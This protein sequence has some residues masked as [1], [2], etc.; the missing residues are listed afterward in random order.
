MV[1]V[2]DRER[3]Q[4]ERANGTDRTPVVF[5]H[6]LW[7]LASS[8]EPWRDLFEQQGYV[9]LAPG[10]P[11]EPE[12]VDEARAHPDLVAGS[13][14]GAVADHLADVVRALDRPPVLVGHSFGGLLVQK[15]AGLGLASATVA[16]SPAP[17]RGVL[18]L[19]ISALK[20]SFPVLRNPANRKRSV[21]LTPEQFRYA[22]TNALPEDEAA[23]VYD[24]FAVPAPG[25][26]LF[27]AATA[28][29]APRSEA[30]ADT[31]SAARGPMLLLG[32]EQDHTVPW[33]ITNASYKRQRKNAGFTD[34]T[35]IP[36]RGHSLVVDD[37]WPD[38]AAKALAFL[39]EHAPTSGALA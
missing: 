10:W 2:T 21:M 31:S 33:A 15:L 23:R 28:N 8:W 4:V 17:A 9:A 14:V 24:R 39:A 12:T 26:P 35:E 34:V 27:Q 20:A 22:F 37:G 36:G 11:G 38:V 18:P 29:V 5:V 7:L 30:S 32:G 3:A 6:G 25:R 19:P 13:G 1:A 16:I